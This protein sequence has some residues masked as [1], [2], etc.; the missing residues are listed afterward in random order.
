MS[1]RVALTSIAA[2]VLAP[3][4]LALVLYMPFRSCAWAPETF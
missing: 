2:M 4:Y 3:I 1:V